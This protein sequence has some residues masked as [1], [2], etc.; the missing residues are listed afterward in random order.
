MQ[1]YSPFNIKDPRYPKQNVRI[2]VPCGMCY[3]CT[4]NRRNQWTYRLHVEVDNSINCY[5]VTLTMRDNEQDG[6]VWKRDVQLFLKRF[7]KESGKITYYAIGEYGGTTWRPHYHLLIFFKEKY[8]DFN[9]MYLLTLKSWNKG[10][11]HLGDVETQSIHYVTKHHITKYLTPEGLNP[12]FAL[13]SKRPYIG[14][15]YVDKM[16]KWHEGDI[17]KAFVSNDKGIKM[18]MPRTFKNKIYTESEREHMSMQWEYKF[19]LDH[20][21][22]FIDYPDRNM[23]DFY[24]DCNNIFK[25]YQEKIKKIHKKQKL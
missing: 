10:N 1:C 4:T 9:N 14:K 15:A 25:S 23:S 18:T 16:K 20:E 2:N 7:R 19:P 21:Q 22:Y 11:I 17:E 24:R 8:F 6:N 3:A 12:T 5:F 13:M